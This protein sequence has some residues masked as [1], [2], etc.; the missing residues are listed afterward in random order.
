MEEMIANRRFANLK[1]GDFQMRSDIKLFSESN[2]RWIV[3]VNKKR[4]EEF[5]EGLKDRRLGC[6]YLGKAG[7]DRIQI[8]D[9]KNLI[10]IPLD[11][12]RDIW[13]RGLEKFL[14]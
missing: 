9:K 12:I 6:T 5:V 10:D 2:T 1:I 14:M 8:S 4:E 3:E 13:G 7:G 11:K